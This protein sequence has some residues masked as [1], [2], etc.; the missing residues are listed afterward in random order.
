M[1]GETIR[2]HPREVYG[3]ANTVSCDSDFKALCFTPG[4]DFIVID[5]VLPF[6]SKDLSYMRA[7]LS[8]KRFNLRISFRYRTQVLKACNRDSG[9]VHQEFSCPVQVNFADNSFMEVIKGF[10]AVR[11]IH[12]ICGGGCQNTA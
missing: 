6:K 10:N 9:T 4:D 3:R 8:W 12:F 7:F 5:A 1:L 11:H 2:R